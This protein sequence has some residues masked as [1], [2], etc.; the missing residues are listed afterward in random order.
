MSISSGTTHAKP[1][2]HTKPANGLARDREAL[3]KAAALIEETPA[4][5]PATALKRTGVT[6][7]ARVRRLSKV[8]AEQK[9]A[10]VERLEKKKALA[11]RRKRQKHR[12][13]AAASREAAALRAARPARKPPSD[14]APRDVSRSELKA[15]PKAERAEPRDD[16]HA[17]RKDGVSGH[18]ESA[19]QQ[20]HSQALPELAAEARE[21]SQSTVN[22]ASAF[23]EVLDLSRRTDPLRFWS[24]M[25]QWSPFGIMLRQTAL[26]AEFFGGNQ[27]R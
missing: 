25:L 26:I 27:R 9:A 15:E 24:E 14:I 21:L 18:V 6:S 11:A 5:R 17:S 8:L 2:G 13:A 3:S 4:M 19:L 1:N 20:S 23:A 22:G 7:P 16:L 10:L 12:E